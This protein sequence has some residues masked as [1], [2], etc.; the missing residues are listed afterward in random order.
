M[1]QFR[2]LVE[3]GGR[4]TSTVD[5]I[6]RT[7]SLVASSADHENLKMSE[8][9]VP[10]FTIIITRAAATTT[11]M[12]FY[13]DD[14]DADDDAD[15][16]AF[17]CI[18]CGSTN[19]Y[20]DESGQLFCA[21]CFSQSQTQQNEAELEYEEVQALVARNR[22][23]NVI[24]VAYNRKS[25]TR[26]R[27]PMTAYDK[28][29]PLPN[30]EECLEGYTTVIQGCIEA[31]C[32]IL[33]LEHYQAKIVEKAVRDM[34]LAF[35]KAWQEGA[36]FYNRYHP[37][38]RIS[39]RD[40]FLRL[41]G[42]RSN[43]NRQ[44]THQAVER[45]KKKRKQGSDIVEDENEE[46]NV[47]E[48]VEEVVEEERNPKKKQKPKVKYKAIPVA[49]LRS[50]LDMYMRKGPKEAALRLHPT[51][52]MVASLLLTALSKL[53]VQAP[54][55]A[56][57]IST[58][59][60][61]LLNAF[62]TIFDKDM[63]AKMDLISYHF[64]MDRVP[65]T[66]ALEW[67][68]KLLFVAAGREPRLITP[69]SV[70]LLAARLVSDLKLENRILTTT[71]ALL[72]HEPH[73]AV[74][75]GEWLPVA[76][77]HLEDIKTRTHILAA[78]AVACKLNPASEIRKYRRDHD[79]AIPWND[80]QV[81]FVQSPSAYIDFVYHHVLE[82]RAENSKVPPNFL[83][84]DDKVKSDEV[85][86]TKETAQEGAVMT[87]ERNP[88]QPSMKCLQKYHAW[89]MTLKHRKAV[90][91]DANGVGHY[92]VYKIA[93]TLEHLHPHYQV[94]LE[95]MSHVADVKA[96]SIHRVVLLLDQEILFLARPQDVS[97][98]TKSGYKKTASLKKKAQKKNEK[99]KQE[100]E[101]SQ[102]E[103]EASEVVFPTTVHSSDIAAN[104]LA[105][106]NRPDND[107]NKSDAIDDDD[108][109]DKSDTIDS[110]SSS[111]DSSDS[112]SDIS[113]AL[114]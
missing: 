67:Q 76:L 84:S 19:F 28:A 87:G 109:N 18:N 103:K 85:L 81:S 25:R 92:M 6:S 99:K 44:L 47:D 42:L 65:T 45:N 105:K 97:E 75:E 86:E 79:H 106:N 95:T 35:L 78:I 62:K 74:E 33:E 112:D 96:V 15:D 64:R 17:L 26:H 71:L 22:G 11:T 20:A 27:Q 2:S 69:A 49:S 37:E 102:L 60:L 5:S 66:E 83:K 72:G 90:W 51:M 30:L 82:G 48:E 3:G 21:L 9:K 43:V 40:A 8:E 46:D 89:L 50:M 61:P 57:W 13:F 1:N 31:V 101:A 34:W 55:I 111:S 80:D 70:P 88:N 29:R 98:M 54:H 23:G 52:S 63:Q 12:S 53:G 4:R 108:D 36:E 7:S 100:K 110:S 68:A 114:F 38:V 10:H 77:E 16:Q 32:D 14:D 39:L 58:G 24:G 73:H 94:L 107:D 56:K 41:P 59:K 104:I 93:T 113:Q 91:A